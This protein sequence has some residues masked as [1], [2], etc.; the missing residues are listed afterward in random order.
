MNISEQIIRAKND[1]D[2]AYEAGKKSEYDAFW[3]NY[4]QNGNRTDYYAG[5]AGVGWTDKTV[6]PKHIVKPKDA[7]M[8]FYK[9]RITF[10]PMSDPRFDFS[11][12]DIFSQAFSY[13]DITKLS[14]I[15]VTKTKQNGARFIFHY[16]QK[17]VT[18]EKLTVGATPVNNNYFQSAFDGAI[19]LQYIFFDGE[20]CYDINMSACKKLAK[21]SIDSAMDHLS[22]TTTAKRTL[23]LSK[24]A[25]NKAYETSEGANDGVE[26]QDW[27]D[28]VN[29]APD[30]W[31]ISVI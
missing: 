18:V 31:I 8:M 11:E 1:L 6:N 2:D 14:A 12:C 21:V 29:A 15:D 13:S 20:I 24:A 19:E 16:A 28:K 9:S 10:D 30:N 7:Q 22:A 3:D 5:F 23:T 25:V 27:N 17:L 4:Q 26:S